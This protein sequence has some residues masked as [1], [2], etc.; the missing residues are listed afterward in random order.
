MKRPLILTGWTGVAVLLALTVAAEVRYDASA[1]STFRDSHAATGDTV[2]SPRRAAAAGA[3]IAVDDAGILSRPLFSPSRRPPAAEGSADAA[4]ASDDLPRLTGIVIDDPIRL[5]IFQP[6][7]P[8]K[9]I[10]LGVGD[11]IS[12]QRVTEID[13]REVVIVGSLGERRIQPVPELSLAAATV[14]APTPPPIL[15]QPTSPQ[16]A[17]V[18]RP[19]AGV[20]REE[21]GFRELAK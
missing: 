11:A 9:A 10:V 5:A 2:R 19:R 8:D 3:P 4:I 15:I 18:P 14:A 21:T 13:A 7:K 12:G 6:K 20:F 1:P 16:H 17:G